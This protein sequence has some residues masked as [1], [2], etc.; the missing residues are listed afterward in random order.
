[1]TAL[2]AFLPPWGKWAGVALLG[3]LL[4]TVPFLYGRH[5]GRAQSE[6]NA[7]K[8]ALDRINEM[9]RNDAKFRNLP[10]HDRCVIFMRDS[11]L[12][13]SECD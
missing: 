4:V 5:I 7:A 11:G 12:P 13:S 9:D 6:A 3:V 2:L 10:A 8:I 1:M